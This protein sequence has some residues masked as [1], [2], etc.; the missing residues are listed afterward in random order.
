MQV[1]KVRLV[2]QNKSGTAENHPNPY[3]DS[4]NRY[5]E[6]QQYDSALVCYHK[7]LAVDHH[8]WRILYQFGQT[9]ML[10]GNHEKAEFYFSRA[11]SK[12]GQENG[13]RAMIYYALGENELARGNNAEAKL[14]FHTVVQLEPDSERGK[15]ALK[16]LQLLTNAD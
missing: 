6:K 13:N 2:E 3:F 11:L 12:C 8:N 16:K 10:T 5:F 1:I 14:Q 7:A 4:G 15:T 9:E